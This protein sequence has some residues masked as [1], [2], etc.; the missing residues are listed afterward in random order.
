MVI[1]YLNFKMET[2]SKGAAQLLGIKDQAAVNHKW[3]SP[4]TNLF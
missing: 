4:T 3:L 1:S 2:I